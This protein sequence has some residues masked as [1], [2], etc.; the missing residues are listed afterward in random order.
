MLK[1]DAK[2]VEALEASVKKYVGDVSVKIEIL[3]AKKE[4]EWEL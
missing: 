1:N 3:G 4:E 2:K